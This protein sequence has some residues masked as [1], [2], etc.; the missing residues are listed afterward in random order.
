MSCLALR[1]WEILQP[2]GCTLAL[3]LPAG[4][5]PSRVAAR[6]LRAWQLR[7][8]RW[9]WHL[10]QVWGAERASTAWR[11][12]WILDGIEFADS[13]VFNPHKWLFTNFDCSAFFCRYPE[14]LISTFSIQPEYLK[15]GKRILC[16]RKAFNVREGLRTQDTR[17]PARALGIPP[18]TKGP[19]KG[20]S[21]DIE[22]LEK[23]YFTIVGWDPDTGSPTPETLKDLEIDHLFA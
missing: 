13:F 10:R 18:Q 20:I 8:C 12:R 5:L 22:S 15:T 3:P 6:P 9:P 1:P 11:E 21:V 2:P 4:R 23:Q 14:T 7:Q 16:L 19:L 17:L